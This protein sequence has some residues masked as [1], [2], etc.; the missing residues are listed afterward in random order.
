MPTIHEAARI[1]ASVEQV[2][3]HLTTEADI[4]RWF[5]GLD[6]LQLSTDYPAIGAT[7][8]W[9]YKVMGMELKGTNTVVTSE[10]G[11]RLAYTMD[12]LLS[13]TWNF[14]LAAA[15]SGVQLD[16][17]LDYTIAGGVLGKLAEPVVQQMNAANARKSIENLK[18]MAEG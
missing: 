1:N 12:G 6:T 15:D 5:E 3:R 7:Q 14:V 18:R 10:P 8:T 17:T 11:A 4:L 16:V 9:T 13:G 2:W